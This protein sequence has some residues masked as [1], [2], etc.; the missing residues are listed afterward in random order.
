LD[1]FYELV[2]HKAG[3]EDWEV[4]QV[5]FEEVVEAGRVT[6]AW[7]EQ[8]KKQWGEDSTLYQNKVLG[9]F[10]SGDD[11]GVI[12]W[13]WVEAANER[14]YVWRDALE[15]S[16]KPLDRLDAVGVDVG[17][18]GDETVFA[19]RSGEVITEIRHHSKQDTMVTVG[20]LFGILSKFGGQAIIDV[21]GIGAGVV[22]RLRELRSE[23]E[24][25]RKD[26]NADP[27][28]LPKSFEVVAFHAAEGTD[29]K[30][31]S[32]EMGFLNKRA[33]A[34]WMMR[35]RLNPANG[36]LVALPPDDKLAGDLIAPRYKVTSSGRYQI[37]KKDEIKKRL[38]RS[39]DTGDGVIMAF[40]ESPGQSIMD[41][42][43]QKAEALKAG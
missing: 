24:A 27:A 39:T 5:S 2:N 34:W 9:K 36:Y 32:G 28:E 42:Y 37:E 35:E 26:P 43:R 1:G 8:R 30:D 19:L 4:R 17:D 41:F 18:T 6:W 3:F 21:I 10:A 7:A 14:W 12:P 22:H 20:Q 23:N 13:P 25:R 15:A 31:R 40:Y 33:E 38:G 16:G 29:R 11:Q